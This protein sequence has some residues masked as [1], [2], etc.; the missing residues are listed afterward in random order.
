MNAPLAWTLA[1]LAACAAL[2]I[3]QVGGAAAGRKDAPAQDLE[4]LLEALADPAR[5]S[6]A[7]REAFDAFVERMDAFDVDASQR[8]ARAMHGSAGAVWSAF[9]L[10]G[11]LRRT[12]PARADD[13]RSA[14]AYEEADS[15]L[16]QLLAAPGL[17]NAQRVDLLQ[18]RA[19]LCAGFA[20]RDAER[21]AL[22]GALGGQGIDGAQILGLAALVRGDAET[23]SVLFASLLDRA[24]FDLESAPWAL[25]GHALSVLETHSS[26]P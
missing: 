7:Y 18:R 21:A 5:A 10:E 8:L 3:G 1:P 23:S 13:P 9:C 12:A 22:G 6:D 11:A 24:S 2:L 25:R 26:A 14:A 16:A 4:R 17:S 15:A 20:R 19:L